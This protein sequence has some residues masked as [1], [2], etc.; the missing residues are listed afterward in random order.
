MSARFPL[1]QAIASAA[2][3]EDH[4]AR[5]SDLPSPWGATLPAVIGE[6]FAAI[7]PARRNAF[8]L[9]AHRS[10]MFGDALRSKEGRIACENFVSAWC[11]D[12]AT[13]QD[14]RRFAEI[15]LRGAAQ[16]WRF[17][18]RRLAKRLALLV[19]KKTPQAALRAVLPTLSPRLGAS[20]G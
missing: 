10:L 16:A 1:Q 15:T 11:P 6:A 19:L 5:S 3:V 9:N 2:A 12:A 18:Q 8:C 17:S 14:N 13:A 20:S 4:L 7:S